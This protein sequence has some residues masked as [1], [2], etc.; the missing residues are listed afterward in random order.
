MDLEG[1]M[2]IKASE[3]ASIS[4]FNWISFKAEMSDMI[5]KNTK[6]DAQKWIEPEFTT[7]TPVSRTVGQ[8]I[9]LG[10]MKKIFLLQ[11]ANNVVQ[12]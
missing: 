5:E 10:V 7:T 1:K 11:F 3:G 12:M 8:V 9:L 2:T 4:T 6:S